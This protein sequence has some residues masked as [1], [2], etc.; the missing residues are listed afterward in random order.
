MSRP[1]A[2]ALVGCQN[3]ALLCTPGLS[4]TLSLTCL[5][6]GSLVSGTRAEACPCST[7]AEASRCVMQGTVPATIALPG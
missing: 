1:E 7:A 5:P 2:S 3:R 6:P 4:L